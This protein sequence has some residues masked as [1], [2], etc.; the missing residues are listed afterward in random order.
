MPQFIKHVGQISSTGKKCV[1][2]FREVPGEAT[3]CLVVETESLPQLY[4]DDIIKAVE[5]DG[6]QADMDFFNYASRVT[7]HD[8][9]NML[10]GMH[11]SNWLKKVPTSAVTMLPTKEVSIG[12]D[13]LNSQLSS[14]K[15]EG[16]TTSGDI[17]AS[18]PTNSN[19][20]PA[21]VLTDSQ[22]ANQMRSQAAY[23][24]KEAERLYTEAES[25]DP[26][27]TS[28]PKPMAMPAVTTDTT[29]KKGRGRPKK[30]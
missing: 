6:A 7:F 9:R 22:I 10:E 3:N 15:N 18:E 1:V 24:R 20:N 13:M 21:G 25:L 28:D 12:L 8:G 2:I 26:Q 11:L 27:T 16:R 30:K 23:F 19:A 17:N 4:H 5:S 29:E 14:L